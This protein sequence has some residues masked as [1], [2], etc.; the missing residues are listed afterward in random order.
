VPRRLSRC[1]VSAR[2]SRVPTSGRA[3]SGRRLLGGRPLP[4]QSGRRGGLRPG[5]RRRA[6]GSGGQSV[7]RLGGR[8]PSGCG[9]LS[10]LRGLSGPGRLAARAVCCAARN[11]G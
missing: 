2:L 9:Q 4:N 5:R 11:P 6:S 3:R 7:L 1:S 8:R 10:R